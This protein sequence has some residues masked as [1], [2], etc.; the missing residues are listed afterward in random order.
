MKLCKLLLT[1]MCVLTASAQTKPRAR[2]LG[3]PFEGVTG[4]LNAIVDVPGV[5]VGHKTLISGEGKLQ[6]GVGPVRTGVTAVW[7]RGKQSS[8]PVFGGFFSQNGNGDMT[9][10]HWLEESGFLDGPV[11]ITNTHSVGVVRDAYLAWLVKNHRQ[12]G[13]NTFDGGFYTYPIVAETYDGFLNDINGFHVKPDDV[14]AAIESASLGPVPEG[15][16]GGGTGMVCYGFKGG[17]GTSSR[18][19]GSYTVGVLV[20]C[21]CGSRGQLRIAGVPVGQEIA[22]N[23]PVASL[24]QPF[25][26]DTGSIIIVVAT[27]APLLPQQTKRLAR[28]ATMGLARTG[29][30]SGNGSGDIFIAFSTANPGAAAAKSPT[31]VSMLPNDSLNGLFEAVVQATEEAIVNA[32]VAAETM[33]GVDG[34]TVTALPHDRLREVLKKYN[35]LVQNQ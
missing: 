1:A 22:A 30:I 34:H 35:R 31:N 26:D 27:D 16:V 32:M 11:L 14:A 29:S 9:G 21:N 6:V 8:D 4:P 24:H 33:T 19:V 12:P 25:R 17:I 13:T 5:E 20:Q 28:R 10:T 23:L 3:V 18:E 2:N 7:P 15:N